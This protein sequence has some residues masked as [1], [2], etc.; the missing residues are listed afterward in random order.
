V[1]TLEHREARGVEDVTGMAVWRQQTTVE[2]A[3]LPGERLR[4]CTAGW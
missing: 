4:A 3:S 2:A 1:A